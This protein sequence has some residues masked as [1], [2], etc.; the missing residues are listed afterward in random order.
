M[1]PVAKFLVAVSVIFL[2]GAV[3]EMV[4]ER[5]S[6]PDAIWLIAT[7]VLLGPIL[8]WVSRAQLNAVAPH[9]AAL[10]LTIVLFEGGTRIRLGQLAKSAPRAGALA[11]TSFALSVIAIAAIVRAASW[12]GLLPEQWGLMHALLVGCI[13][14]GPSSIIIMPAMERARLDES[15]ANLVGLESAITDAFCVVGT[16]AMIDLLVSGAKPGA[17]GASLL[18]SF[19]LALLIGV[20]CGFAW[21]LFLKL[22]RSSEHAYPITLAALLLLYV[23]IDAVKGSAALGIL[24]FAIVLGNA[25]SI[26][27]TFELGEGF[28]LGKDVASFHSR[29]TFIIK[30]LFFTFMG[31]MLGP[32]WGLLA[33]GVLL[34]LVI[35][36]A[37]V[38]AALLATLGSKLGT[39]GKKMVVLALPRGMAAGVLATMPAFAGV[40]YTSELPVLVFAC[41][42]TT[43]VLFAAGFPTVRKQLPTAPPEPP[44]EAAS[45]GEPSGST[46]ALAP[47]PQPT[48]PGAPL[49]G[50]AVAVAATPAPAMATP[51]PTAPAPWPAAAPAAPQAAATPL[52]P[53][54]GEPGGETRER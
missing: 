14:G 6:I 53:K 5:T 26:S 34:A 9:F 37:R 18:R 4:F 50:Q 16:S 41:I 27:K 7:G 25:P 54:T 42:V 17:A 1:D 2:I 38:P 46:P 39:A 23:A 20:V 30:S 8:G 13:L 44:A 15:L 43:I 47:P 11:A 19:G 12:L 51:P 22:L 31:L 21:L 29:M 36:V 48:P 10:T 35:A 49:P 40:P 33:I 32:P 52:P 24:S 45:T 28:E 3:G